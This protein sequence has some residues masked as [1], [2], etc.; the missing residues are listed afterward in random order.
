MAEIPPIL[1]R[2]KD[3]AGEILRLYG[4][5]TLFEQQSPFG[6]RVKCIDLE[7]GFAEK[8]K[9]LLFVTDKN[10]L[11]IRVFEHKLS[12]AESRSR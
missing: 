8:S 9:G 11:K 6:L 5:I 4:V 7:R 3:S 2:R 12:R 10:R 1:G